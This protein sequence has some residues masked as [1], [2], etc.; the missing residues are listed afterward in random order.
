LAF[1]FLL[2]VRGDRSPVQFR[3]LLAP[4]RGQESA[5]PMVATAS[6]ARRRPVSLA[7]LPGD[8]VDSAI[9]GQRRPA[10]CIDE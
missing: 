4:A 10:A 1:A 7:R 9:S 5:S 6:A 3:E 2:R 8:A